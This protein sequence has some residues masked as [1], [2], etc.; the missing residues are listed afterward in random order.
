M[1]PLNQLDTFKMETTIKS[2][3]DFGDNKTYKYFLS[4]LAQNI[5]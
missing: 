2:I 3:F 4:H 1:K 5:K